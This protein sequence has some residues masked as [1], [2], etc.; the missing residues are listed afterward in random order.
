MSVP[1]LQCHTQTFCCC[2]CQEG[3][4]QM[5]GKGHRAEM[6]MLCCSSVGEQKRL[7]QVLLCHFLY[8][9]IRALNER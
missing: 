4:K 3:G 7:V 6:L 1:D 5:N 9:Y 8:V 2:C